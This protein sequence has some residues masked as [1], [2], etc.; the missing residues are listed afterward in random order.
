MEQKPLAAVHLPPTEAQTP[1]D[2]PSHSDEL[3]GDVL[4]GHPDEW[5]AEVLNEL[6]CEESDSPPPLES[7]S[8]S[9]ETPPLPPSSS[10]SD[11]FA[12]PG[13]SGDRTVD[14]V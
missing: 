4:P 1:E 13:G 8:D 14:T 6:P 3:T 5:Q 10:G 9:S 11:D 2:G 12:P 7:E